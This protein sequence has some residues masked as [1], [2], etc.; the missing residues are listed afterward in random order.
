MR[1]A[2]RLSS[3]SGIRDGEN[4]PRDYGAEEIWV[5]MTGLRNPIG[6]LCENG[7]FPTAPTPPP[8]KKAGIA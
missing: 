8:Q 2:S 3:G 4:K 6:G 5:R 1:V 7:C